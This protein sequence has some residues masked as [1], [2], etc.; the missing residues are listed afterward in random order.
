MTFSFQVVAAPMAGISNRAY[1]DIVCSQG[2]DLAY[3]E[4]VSAQAIT[5]GNKKTLE[6]MDIADEASPRLVQLFGSS[7][8]HM[9]YAAT[10]AQELGAEYL[11]INMGCPVPK[12][13]RNGEGSALMRDP[14]L[15]ASLVTAAAACGLP[16]S[17]KMR[18]G[19]DVA[20]RNAVEFAQRMEAAGAA[21]IAIH[22]RTREQFYTGQ[23]DW[24]I[25]AAVKRAVNIPVIGNGDIFNAD[26]ALRMLE[27]TGCDG[28][29]VGR[30]M[31]G[32]PWIF[33]DIKAVLAGQT[34]SGRPDTAAVV[35]MALANLHEHIRRTTVA[36]CRR[37]GS[38]DIATKQLA[39]QLAVC[40]MRNQL[41]WYLKGM[42]HAAELRRQINVLSSYQQIAELLQRYVAETAD[43]EKP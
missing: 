17:V 9:R 24:Q 37:E 14:E 29:M 5:Y 23:A 27:Q 1:R 41:G 22:G 11:D 39:E 8:E 13:V 7:P 35:A 12:V 33:A 15:A 31:M 26:D 16:V 32:N 40:S 6:L 20:H 18:S 25:I 10:V 28:V 30:G 19:W 38:S 34:P 4:M 21:F 36:V 3:G 42:R 43:G 2:A